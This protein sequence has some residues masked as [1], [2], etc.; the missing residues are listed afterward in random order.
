MSGE[1]DA[2]QSIDASSLWPGMLQLAST[3]MRL[4]VKATQA[5][6]DLV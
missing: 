1:R 5:G 6:D 4:E 2:A 3:A